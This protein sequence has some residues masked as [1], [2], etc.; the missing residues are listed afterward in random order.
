MRRL[1]FLTIAVAAAVFAPLS[2]F[3]QETGRKQ[4]GTA[5]LPGI[6]ILSSGA[7]EA[8]T[9]LMAG[10][11]TE[12]Q[13]LGWVNGRS[14]IYEPRFAGGDPSRFPGFATDLV[15]RKV[16]VIFAGGH[17][18]AKAAQIATATIPIVALANDVEEAGLVA[19]IA[20]PESNITG[21]SIFGSELDEK[22][23]ELLMELVPAAR[24]VAVL[25]DSKARPSVAQVADNA[26]RLGIE[27]VL[28]EAPSLDK[29]HSALEAVAGAR[30]PSVGGPVQ[31]ASRDS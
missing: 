9:P 11:F 7:G 26:Q 30:G 17:P 18:A 8:S 25:T 20:R 6:G 13:R 15:D 19:N 2:G 31:R 4:S 1:G 12:L 16:N 29:L 14:A 3:A 23:L 28:I 10:V 27:L 22:R 5:K 24:R 21:V